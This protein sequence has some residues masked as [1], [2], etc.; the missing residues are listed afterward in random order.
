MSYE[1]STP[2]ASNETARPKLRLTRRGRLA[3]WA[4]AG[5]LCIPTGILVSGVIDSPPTICAEGS[6]P[7]DG[8]ATGAIAD[9]ARNARVGTPNNL[10]DAGLDAAKAIPGKY[11]H[12]GDTIRACFEGTH[13]VSGSVEFVPP[14]PQPTELPPAK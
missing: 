7:K 14:Q 13:V 11:E 8:N 3:I 10:F 4:G 6:V 9:A 5:V 2:T 12:H 1:N